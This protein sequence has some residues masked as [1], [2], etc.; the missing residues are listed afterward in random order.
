M[1]RSVTFVLTILSVLLPTRAVLGDHDCLKASD[2]VKQGIRVSDASEEELGFYQQALTL[3]PD[4]AEAV[5]NIGIVLQKRGKVAEAE[6]NLRQALSIKNDPRFRVA[7]GSLFQQEKKYDLA[8]EHYQVALEAEEKLP[9]AYQG[10]AKVLQDEGKVQEAVSL[11]EDA[12]KFLPLDTV[13][14][15]NLGILY[16]VA[17]RY[18]DAG[19]EYRRATSLDSKNAKAFYL[20]G[21]LESRSGNLAEG[22]RAL[23]R[24]VELDGNYVE[25]ILGLA[26]IN[27]KMGHSVL[28]QLGYRRVLKIHPD[29][30]LAR[31]HLIALLINDHAYQ[32]AVEILKATVA[33][34]PQRPTLWSSYGQAQMELGQVLDA[35]NS[36]KRALELDSG[37]A[38]IHNNLG[39]LYHRLG[40]IDK[41]RAQLQEAMRLDPTIEDI[42]ENLEILQ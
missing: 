7:L 9:L 21:M 36:F 8:K 2:L 37:N 40:K 32:E 18:K 28:A 22:K 24:A 29:N 20:R 38:R 3:C 19:G 35:E 25:A 42:E 23:E 13:T 11:L 34:N 10:M 5:F 1:I 12:K 30:I 26:E 27:E 31:E 6:K 41:A 14:A 4:M 17:H 33:L 15:L 39:V 16:E